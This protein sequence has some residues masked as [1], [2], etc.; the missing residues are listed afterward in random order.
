WTSFNND[1]T[2]Y[3][4]NFLMTGDDFDRTPAELNDSIN[5]SLSVGKI[6]HVLNTLKNSGKTI[7]IDMIDE[8]DGIWGSTPLPTDGRWTGYTPS[9]PD[10]AFSQLMTIF[11]G[12]SRPMV[13]WPTLGLD[14]VQN[15]INWQN[16]PSF[17]ADYTSLYWDNPDA[18]FLYANRPSNWEAVHQT[19]DQKLSYTLPVIQQDKPFLLLANFVGPYYIKNGAG[20]HYIPGQDT[21]IR[22]GFSPDQ[23]TALIMDGLGWGAAGLRMYRYDNIYDGPSRQNDA[24]GT[25]EQTGANPFSVGVPRWNA[26]SYAFNVAKTLDPYFLSPLANAVDQGPNIEAAARSGTAGKLLMLTNLLETG[27]TVNPDLSSYQ[28]GAGTMTRYLISGSGSSSQSM[29]AAS[30]DT[31]TLAPGQ[32]VVYVFAATGGSDTTPP[33]APTNLTATAASS[34]QINLSWT[35][36]T[37]DTGVTGYNIYRGSSSTTLGFLASTT[38][39]SY[40]NSGL[41]ASTTYFYGVRAFDAAGNTSA[42]STVVST[43]TPAAGDTTPPTAPTNLT[44]TAASSTQINLSWTASTDNVGVTGYNVYRGSSSTT[45]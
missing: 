23:V 36:S 45:L 17:T 43:S 21:L 2:A 34:T 10:T 19:I 38:Q 40:N 20:N 44:A 3:G 35:A 7:G 42:T 15:I 41:T 37:D 8:A 22:A 14:A 24:T 6:Q 28:T 1:L 32:T 30:S 11:N 31:L 9:I 26:M 33:T 13:A 27:Q 18:F 12:T 29:T 5:D 25:V 39:T 16:N 4:F